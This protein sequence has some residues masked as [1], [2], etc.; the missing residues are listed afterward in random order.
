MS[1]NRRNPEQDRVIDLRNSNQSDPGRAASE[2]FMIGGSPSGLPGHG[3]HGNDGRENQ[4][5]FL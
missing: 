1:N 2:E 4:A 5:L 3:Q